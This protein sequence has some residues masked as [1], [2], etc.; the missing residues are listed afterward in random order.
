MARVMAAKIQYEPFSGRFDP[1]TKQPR[2]EM[3][4]CLDCGQNQAIWLFECNICEETFASCSACGA[5]HHHLRCHPLGEKTQ[6]YGQCDRCRQWVQ[7]SSGPCHVEQC[8]QCLHPELYSPCDVCGQ[9]CQRPSGPCYIL[10]CN[11]CLEDFINS[12]SP[13]SEESSGDEA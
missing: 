1:D 2:A 6:H 9:Q 11:R 5:D 10:R 8:D 4:L 7:Q 13:M 3:G 12:L